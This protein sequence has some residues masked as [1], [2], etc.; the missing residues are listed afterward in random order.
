[1]GYSDPTETLLLNTFVLTTLSVELSNGIAYLGFLWNVAV[2]LSPLPPSL[3]LCMYSK[4][5]IIKF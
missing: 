3:Q 1:M 5:E 2:V 4:T